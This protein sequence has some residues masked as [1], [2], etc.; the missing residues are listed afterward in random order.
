MKHKMGVIFAMSLAAMAA[1]PALA[2]VT[3]SGTTNYIPV[4]KSGSSIGNSVMYQNSLGVGIGTTSPSWELDVN[5]HI[6]TA[7]GF[8]IGGQNAITQ[9]PSWGNLAV[10]YEALPN[11]PGT[12]NTAV[13]VGASASVTAGLANNTAV[14]YYALHSNT[15]GQ[16]NTALGSLALEHNTSGSVNTAV[17]HNALSYNTTGGNNTAVGDGALL[18]NTTGGYNTAVGAAALNQ[19]QGGYYNTALGVAAL[20]FNNTGQY[21]TALGYYALFNNTGGLNNIA[22]GFQ[23]ANSVSSGGS[24]NIHI[25][26]PGSSG[27][28]STIR[29]GGAVNG[30]PA[31]TSFYAAGIAGTNV[32]GAP[33][34]V[35]STG[36]LG[37]V[38]SSIR[39][40]EDVHD[41]A[42]ASAGLLQLRPVTYRYKEPFAD[43]SRPVDY[44]LIAEEVAEIYPNLVVRSDDGEI[45]TVQYQ[46]L[47]PMLLN[48]MQKLEK[49]L[50]A[51]EARLSAARRE[52]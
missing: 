47:T 52:Q 39:F 8:L 4:W 22:I 27:D 43:G 29:I 50:A 3:G 25:G 38:N 2:Q 14:G 45:Q 20:Y 31:Q 35:S 49:R 5:G 41:M 33:V 34:I 10:G 48:E 19:N 21:N 12:N 15:E 51:L 42:G 32:A 24:N 7:S 17:G 23:A 6:N 37:V 26:S 36:Q 28:V 11:N 30:L 13:G 9:S 18:E 16:P 40:K 46:Q 1:L 44:G